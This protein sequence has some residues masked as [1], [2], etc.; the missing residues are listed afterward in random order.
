MFALTRPQM[1][2]QVV[3]KRCDNP[4]M[5]SRGK[6]SNE[7]CRFLYGKQK[8]LTFCAGW[9]TARCLGLRDLHYHPPQPREAAPWSLARKPG[10]KAFHSSWSRGGGSPTDCSSEVGCVAWAGEQGWTADWNRYVGPWNHCMVMIALSWR[11]GAYA[12]A[13]YNAL[14]VWLN[15]YSSCTMWNLRLER[16][17]IFLEL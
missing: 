10:S 1:V 7:Y 17:W 11:C 4:L 15:P 5:N 16:H 8:S 13:K 6:S 9:P 12:G 2:Q 14:Y 3:S